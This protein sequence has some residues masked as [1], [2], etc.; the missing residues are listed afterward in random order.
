MGVPD[1]RDWDC[2][3]WVGLNVYPKIRRYPMSSNNQPD[4]LPMPA[5]GTAQDDDIISL[6]EIF[7]VL[8]THKWSI[9]G[10]TFAV[11]LITTLIVFKLT[12]IYQ[13]TTLLQIEQEQAKVVSIE[14]VYGIDG[15]GDSYLNTQFEVLKSRSVLE[16]VVNKLNLT[17]NP[18]FNT[19]LREAPWYAQYMN[20]RSWFGLEAPVD[21]EAEDTTLRDTISTLGANVSIAPVKKTQVVRINATSE[22]PKLAANIANAIANAYIESYMESKLSLTLN[23]TDWMQGR[24][25][26]LSDKLRVAEQNLQEYREQENL[27]ELEG[28][29]TL[30]SNELK[31]LTTELVQ[32]RRKLAISETIY[33]RIQSGKLKTAEDYESLEAVLA[34][35]LIQE[36][37]QEQAKVE[38][39]ISDMSR[40]YGPK[41]P[42]MRSAHSELVSIKQNIT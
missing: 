6:R 11:T 5:Q 33:N 20:W 28:V 24:M 19:A 37:K 31:A 4:N 18:E 35:P 10:F 15:G 1:A 39:Q 3:L 9:I 32:V 14:E 16:K 41:H 8:T 34:H 21:D 42:K 36:L 12:P 13:A 2:A 22:N 23:A 7:H 40:R 27:V 38:R 26:D 25:T 17:E 29:L 30:S